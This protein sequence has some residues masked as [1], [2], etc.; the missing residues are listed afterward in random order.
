MRCHPSTRPSR[1]LALQRRG[2]RLPRQPYTLKRRPL[3]LLLLLLHQQQAHRLHA[4]L[5]LRPR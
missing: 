3:L 1:C 5:Q 2:H 4:E